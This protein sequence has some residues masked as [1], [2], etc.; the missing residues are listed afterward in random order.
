ME[1]S[2]KEDFE[3]HRLSLSLYRFPFF[4][5]TYKHCVNNALRYSMPYCLTLYRKETAQGTLLRRLKYQRKSWARLRTQTQ[6]LSNTM[7]YK[8]THQDYIQT[9]IQM[10]L[11]RC[12][13]D[14]F[15]TNP[16]F[17]LHLILMVYFLFIIH[18]SWKVSWSHW[19][20]SPWT[21]RL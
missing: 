3:K 19:I 4:S 8:H 10:V 21:K 2:Y 15:L 9:S 17:K 5:H 1:N 11:Y 20:L 7:I 6:M 16:Y 13:V 12:L 14:S 18:F